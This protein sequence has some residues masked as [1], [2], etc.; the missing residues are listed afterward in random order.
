MGNDLRLNMSHI[1]LE[2][3]GGGMAWRVKT[4]DL[5]VDSEAGISHSARPSKTL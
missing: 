1:A 4:G 2:T 3:G 5:T